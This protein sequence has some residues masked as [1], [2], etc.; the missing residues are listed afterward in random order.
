ME[1]AAVL[2]TS[3]DPTATA[4]LRELVAACHPQVV[5]AGAGLAAIAQAVPA[6]PGLVPAED[7]PG[8][9]WFEVTALPLRGRGVAPI[10]YRLR[11]AGKTVLFS[12]RIPIKQHVRSATALFGEIS[13]SRDQTLDYLASVYR[14]G[15][16]RPDLWLP[17]VPVD[18]QNA[19]LYD[20]DW[21]DI[22]ADNYRLGYRSLQL[23]TDRPPRGLER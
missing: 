22:L 3:C 9:G 12:G 2:L 1:P 21:P 23:A 5:V 6:G 15:E 8:R 13:Q 14:L 16:P 17:A 19:N 7:L 18:G 11:W 10:A 4:G 20:T